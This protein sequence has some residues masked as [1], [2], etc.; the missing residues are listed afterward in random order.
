MQVF[1]SLGS[2]IGDKEKNIREALNR[3]DAAE[4]MSRT[5]LSEI[6]GTK[7]FGFDGADFLNCVAGFS[8]SLS[9]EDLLDLC[10][11]TERAMGRMDMPEYNAEGKRIYHDRIID[12][13]ILTYGDEKID[14]PT[15]TIPH[16]QL[17]TRPFIRTLLE[18]I[19]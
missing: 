17:E 12:I 8:C 19:L 5:A 4:G 6:I 9:P 10:K 3:L 13:D 16:P 2:N 1:L 7:A 18:K 11:K 15:L 14:T